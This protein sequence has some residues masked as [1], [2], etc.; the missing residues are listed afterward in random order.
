MPQST[1]ELDALK[2]RPL[3]AIE[4]RHI[5]AWLQ[6]QASASLDTT[7][8]RRY[9]RRTKPLQLRLVGSRSDHPAVSIVAKRAHRLNAEGISADVATVDR[10]HQARG[11]LADARAR[12][13]SA[14]DAVEVKRA[15]ALVA[16][17]AATVELHT[18]RIAYQLARTLGGPLWDKAA[19]ESFESQVLQGPGDALGAFEPD[20][21]AYP[22]LVAGLARYRELADGPGANIT[23]GKVRSPIRWM[24]LRGGRTDKRVGR[25]RAR[26][27]AEGFA[28]EPAS[29]PNRL[30]PELLEALGAFQ[31]LHGLGGSGRIDRLTLE[32]LKTPVAVRAGQIRDTLAA[33]RSHPG[34]KKAYRLVVNIPAFELR[35]LQRDKVLAR[36]RVVVGNN[37]RVYDD[38]SGKYSRRNRTPTLSSRI[39]LLVLNPA[40]RV[41]RRI[42]EGELDVRAQTRPEVYDDFRFRYDRDGVE[43]AVQLPGPRNA[44]GRVKFVF[45]GGNGVYLHDTPKKR[46]FGKSY[47]AL[48]H[49]C[50]RVDNALGLAR[51]LL[52]RDKHRIRWSVAR[53]LLRG[54]R[55]TPLR[56]NRAVPIYL[57]YVMVGASADGE[58]RFYPDIYRRGAPRVARRP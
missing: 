5:D 50:V 22:I 38:Y 27:K 47:R 31:K 54:M 45:T 11:A 32:A 10:L 52:E 28:V 34:R 20:D 24:R 21:P 43:W 33:I 56:L 9:G 42:K 29:R 46:D 51:T 48:S 26:L 25:L 53:S 7:F 39:E 44:L 14:V 2:A 55:E 15:R 23:I 49:G 40:W 57:D 19:R 36:H 13:L 41:P 1:A 30:D 4:P 37:K 18:W 6:E 17:R 3:P 8:V 35:L 12:L 58:L 16:D